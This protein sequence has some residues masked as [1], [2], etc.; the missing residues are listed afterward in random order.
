MTQRGVFVVHEQATSTK[1]NYSTNIL[2]VVEIDC[3]VDTANNNLSLDCNFNVIIPILGEIHVAEISGDLNKGITV[4][5]GLWGIASGS[6]TFS[7]RSVTNT[8]N[9]VTQWVFLT[10]QLTTAVHVFGGESFQLFPVPS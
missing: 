2:N 9:T 6:A 4:Q 10:L 1:H 3:T 5:I 8:D 7:I